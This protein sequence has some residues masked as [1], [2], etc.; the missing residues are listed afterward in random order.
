MV[1]SAKLELF[2]RRWQ[3]GQRPGCPGHP[4]LDLDPENY[5]VC[6]CPAMSRLGDEGMPCACEADIL[7]T[8]SMHAC[9]LASGNPAGL[10][11]WNNLHNEDEELVNVWHCGVFP[12]SF[13]REPPKIGITRSWSPAGS[14]SENAWAPSNWWPSPRR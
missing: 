11:D 8:L 2:L 12:K 9:L 1:R 10:A 5:G 4:M 13:A 6:S 7:G 14:P 3:R